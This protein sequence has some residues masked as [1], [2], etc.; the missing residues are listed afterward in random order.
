MADV[1]RY[2]FAAIWM[3]AHI[4]NLRNLGYTLLWV[5]TYSDMVGVYR[6]LSDVMQVQ[7]PLWLCCTG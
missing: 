4:E 7:L 6:E 5:N 3:S 2:V 1:T